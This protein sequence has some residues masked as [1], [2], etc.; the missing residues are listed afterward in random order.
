MDD[1]ISS[2]L[3]GLAG[4]S[5]IAQQE[6]IKK[7]A[8]AKANAQYAAEQMFTGNHGTIIDGECQRVEIKSIGGGS[9]D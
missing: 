8:T 7:S 3:Y 2:L 5:A 1:V 9:G 6:A 4:A